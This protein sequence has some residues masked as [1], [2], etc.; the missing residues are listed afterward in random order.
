MDKMAHLTLGQ[1]KPVQMLAQ[2]G[3][4]GLGHSLQNNPSGNRALSLFFLNTLFLRIIY[5]Y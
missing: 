5:L 3:T 1:L 2:P 4:L